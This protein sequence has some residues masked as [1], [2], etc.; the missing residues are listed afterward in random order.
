MK[1]ETPTERL[2][3]KLASARPERDGQPEPDG[4][5]E[6]DGQPAPAEHAAGLVDGGAVTINEA[7]LVALFRGV[8][9]ETEEAE[10]EVTPAAHNEAAYHPASEPQADAHEADQVFSKLAEEAARERPFAAPAKQ[11]SARPEPLA[12]ASLQPVAKAVPQ[13]DGVNAAG[14]LVEKELTESMP[15]VQRSPSQAPRSYSTPKPPAKPARTE[16]VIA[17]AP[18]KPPA[19][20][21]PTRPAEVAAVTPAPAAQNT[22]TASVNDHP[23]AATVAPVTEP[24]SGGFQQKWLVIGGAV[25]AVG[26][27]AIYFSRGSQSKPPSPAQVVASNL[28]AQTAPPPDSL[29]PPPPAQPG[30]PNPAA[31]TPAAPAPAPVKQPEPPKA[32]TPPPVAAPVAAVAPTPAPIAKTTAKEF[33]PP[34][35]ASNRPATA[36]TVPTDAP[37]T[38]GTVPVGGLGVVNTTG[39]NIAAPP[40]PAPPAP[41]PLAATATPT[42]GR[43]AAAVLVTKVLPAYPLVARKNKIEGNVVFSVKVGK[44]GKVTGLQPVSGNQLLYQAAKEA[45][46][47]WVY[48]PATVNG[49]ARED[50]VQ[51]TLNF[52]LR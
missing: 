36:S 1:T 14:A 50:T 7:N 21:A 33:V 27:M 39:A 26:S 18:A 32:I 31:A 11:E 45:L 17:R 38:I 34:T 51:V 15:E 41:A 6:R 24:A 52:S 43:T 25:L 8:S 30:T 49:E 47:Q 20:Q 37:P 29:V 9:D 42:P 2:L 10:L 23:T 4:H 19:K 48:K 16:R 22:R 3:A 44:D 13:E 35:I 12:K 5:L 40:R 46:Q 28:P